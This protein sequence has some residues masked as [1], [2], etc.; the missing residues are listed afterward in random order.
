M[1]LSQV[2]ERRAV[3]RPQPDQPARP[4]ARGRHQR[5]RVG[6]SAGEVSAD[7]RK[8]L[9]EIALPPGYR[10]AF[11]G[12]TKNMQESFGYALSALALAVIFIYMIL[13]SQFSS[14]LQP[15]ALM[16]SLPLTLIGV[17]LALLIFRSTLEHVLDH[18]RG[19]ADGPGD[20]E[21]HPAGRLRHPRA[22]AGDATRTRR[23]CR[24]ARCGCGR[25]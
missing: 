14:F 15:L 17:V 8:A 3:D 18:R 23:C 25:S 7:I 6:R 11:G 9:D 4:E 22:R 16:T 24:P 10:Y 12:S 19:D 1:R 5:Q 2:A 13:A 20:Q 21:R